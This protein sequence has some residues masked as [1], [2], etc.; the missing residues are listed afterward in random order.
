MSQQDLNNFAF[1]TNILKNFP[2]TPMSRGIYRRKRN[3]ILNSTHNFSR[4]FGITKRDQVQNSSNFQKLD[5]INPGLETLSND[6]LMDEIVDPRQ[7][8][9]FINYEIATATDN[10]TE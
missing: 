10:G 9:N 7:S 2:N 6:K 3:Q 5:S 8:Q 4:S 1:E